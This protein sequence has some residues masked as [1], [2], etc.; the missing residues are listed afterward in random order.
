MIRVKKFGVKHVYGMNTRKYD[1]Q[2]VYSHIQSVI[3][4]RK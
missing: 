1:Y 2:H 3:L 4:H